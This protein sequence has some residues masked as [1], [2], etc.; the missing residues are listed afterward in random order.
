M[1]NAEIWKDIPGYEGLYM[2]SNIGRVRS[3]DRIVKQVDGG[4]LCERKLKSKTLSLNIRKNGRLKVLLY[5]GGKREEYYV[6][7]LVLTSFVGACPRGKECCH[8]NDNCADNR[9]SNLYWGTHKENII[10]RETND[11]QPKGEAIS[12]SK[13]KNSDIIQIKK[14]LKEGVLSQRKIGKMFGVSKSRIWDIKANRA[15]SHVIA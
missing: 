2:V 14:L 3:N 8:K 6:H 9:L 12:N 11:R 7:R 10:D 5:K 15:W 4:T 13:L 1:K